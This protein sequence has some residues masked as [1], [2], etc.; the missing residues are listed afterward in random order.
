MQVRK[1]RPKQDPRSASPV[2]V[3][4]KLVMPQDSLK[5]VPSKV[6]SIRPNYEPGGGDVE[7]IS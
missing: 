5:N 7:V 2:V 4:K 3:R 1:Y 6:D